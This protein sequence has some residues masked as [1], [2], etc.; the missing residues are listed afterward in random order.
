ML[1]PVLSSESLEPTETQQEAVAFITQ[2]PFSFVMRVARSAPEAHARLRRRRPD[3][4]RAPDNN[5]SLIESPCGTGKTLIAIILIS[6]YRRPTVIVTCNEYLRLS[7]ATAVNA[8]TVPGTTPAFSGQ[9]S[10]LLVKQA[11][12]KTAELPVLVCT[13]NEFFTDSTS[14]LQVLETLAIILSLG[15]E[16]PLVIVDEIHK[17]PT[18]N[19]NRSKPWESNPLLM[20]KGAR[21][22]GMTGFYGKENHDTMSTFA[23]GF[24]DSVIS[25]SAKNSVNRGEIR[26][27]TQQLLPVVCSEDHVCPTHET[28]DDVST[29]RCRVCLRAMIRGV[30]H[31]FCQSTT[32]FIAVVFSDSLEPLAEVDKVLAEPEYKAFSL[33]DG[34]VFQGTSKV[35]QKSYIVDE[36]MARFEKKQ[37]TIIPCSR[38]G[39]Q[40]VNIPACSKIAI[41]GTNGNSLGQH[42]QRI[43]RIRDQKVRKGGLCVCVHPV[44]KN[45]TGKAWFQDQLQT[46]MNNLERA[47]VYPTVPVLNRTLELDPL[48]L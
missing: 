46:F 1:G 32:P 47:F 4:F 38:A 28:A 3:L 41:L 16:T 2:L 12:S 36:A 15:S 39:D 43:G 35:E 17:L 9:L 10:D 6:F 30:V 31:M 13:R 8:Q 23:E 24:G 45:G 25:L 29:G 18:D 33:G 20:A 42:I 7:F 14:K 34:N 26:E 27:V 22:V 5:W 11:D 40:G 48:E 21:L 19:T 37:S 44:D